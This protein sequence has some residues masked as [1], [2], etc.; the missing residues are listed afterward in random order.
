MYQLPIRL[1]VGSRGNCGRAKGFTLVELLVV[2]GIIALLIAIL[3]PVL[4]K[5]RSAAN[6]VACLSNVKQL[7][8][9]FLMY[10]NDNKS[11]FPT[12]A[13]WADGVSYTQLDDDWIWWQANRKLDDSA[14]AKYLGARGE[15]L[16][17]LLRCPADSFEGRKVHPGILPGQGAFLYSY[18][19]NY[20]LAT[21]EVPGNYLFSSSSVRTK[22]TQW[23]SPSKKVLL[24]E[25]LSTFAPV[26]SYVNS[27]T[28]RHGAGVSR[29]TSAA[30][31]SLVSTVFLDGHA[32]SVD[33]DLTNDIIQDRPDAQ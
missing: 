18:G 28:Q 13:F 24:T 19:M 7:Y 30:M 4:G 8:N 12:C 33:E 25:L 20:A 1:R 23:R 10:C 22:I 3:L 16:Q 14:I 15:K 27:L 17:R 26:W 9:G 11:Y 31:G 29:K 32:E 21:N 6:R 5:A 2:I